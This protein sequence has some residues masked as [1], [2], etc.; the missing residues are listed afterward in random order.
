MKPGFYIA[1]E[2]S[3]EQYHAGP[4]VSNSGLKLIGD[5]TPRHFYAQYLD[6]NRRRDEGSAAK[7]IGTAVHAACLEPAEFENQYVI[8]PYDA[9]NAAGYKAW[10]K[11]QTKKILLPR[12]YDSVIGM[13]EAIYTHP[14]ASTLLWDVE[15]EHFE[16][17]AYAI[18]PE[19]GVMVRIRMDALTS[20]GWIVDVKKTQDASPEGAAKT[21]AN[22]GYY[23][24]AAMYTDVLT[25]ASGQAPA[26]FAFVFVE[27][28]YPHAVAVYCLRDEDIYR[29]RMM[30][31]RNLQ[32]YA[33]CLAENK[34]PGYG[35]GASYIDL[36]VWARKQIDNTIGAI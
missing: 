20:C 29:G 26:G 33:E 3:A 31:R 1:T 34:W 21:I 22:Y 10:S 35:E 4:G 9:R 32:L 12:D 19:T 24:Q 36:P 25:L 7:F 2:L 15:P 27:E 17:S 8:S 16:Y 30:Y 14:T 23:H 5:K 13:R 6:P 28:Q 18:D 11:E